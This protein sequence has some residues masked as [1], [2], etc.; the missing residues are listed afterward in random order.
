MNRTLKEATVKRY[1]YDNHQQLRR[2][3]YD[4][5]NAY[6]FA[7]R[8]KTLKGLTSYEFIIKTW[9][10]EP[11]RFIINPNHHTLG[12]NINLPVFIKIS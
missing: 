3:L 8:L 6:N 10:S 9:Q 12:L 4:F 5:V 1:Y 11:D 2:H 7:K